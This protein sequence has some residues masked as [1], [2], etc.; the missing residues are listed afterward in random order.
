MADFVSNGESNPVFETGTHEITVI[1]QNRF[2]VAHQQGV[3][4]KLFAETIHR[5]EIEFQI[6]FGQIEHSNRQFAF[7]RMR[8][9][10][11]IGFLP[12]T[13]LW[14]KWRFEFVR[15]VQGRLALLII[16]TNFFKSS[17]EGFCPE[18]VRKNT[19]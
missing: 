2:E 10:Q 16:S 1:H 9:S 13:L 18:S 4:I 8:V 5:N 6:E 15:V 14:N 3:N 19:G 11:P 7:S 12:D 17:R